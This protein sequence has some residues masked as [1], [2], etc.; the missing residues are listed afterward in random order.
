MLDMG[1]EAEMTI[2]L[3]NMNALLKSEN[4]EE[5]YEQEVKDAG[6]VEKGATSQYRLTAMFSATMPADVERLARNYLRHPAVISIGDQDSGK[7]MRIEQRIMAL[8]SEKMKDGALD[9]LLGQT[10]RDEK[11]IVFVNEKKTADFVGRFLEKKNYGKPVVVLHG[12]KAQDQV[13]EEEEE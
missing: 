9:K 10:N 4:E 6:A 1:F 12:G 11:I 3:D 7:N 13:S 2:I 8:G 5:A